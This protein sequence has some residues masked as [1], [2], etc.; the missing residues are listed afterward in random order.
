MY[1]IKYIATN[2]EVYIQA[3]SLRRLSRKIEKYLIKIAGIELKDKLNVSEIDEYYERFQISYFDRQINIQELGIQD[4][5]LQGMYI[6][7]EEIMMW[8]LTR[9]FEVLKR[10]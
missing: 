8:S 6:Y 2:G 1:V 9:E 7:K 10:W 3:K 5:A 4:I